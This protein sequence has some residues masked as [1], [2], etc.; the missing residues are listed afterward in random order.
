MA[1]F[2][3]VGMTCCV[4]GADSAD[5]WLLA[6]ERSRWRLRRGRRGAGQA[7]LCTGGF[8]AAIVGA[9]TGFVDGADTGCGAC[10]CVNSRKAQSR[11]RD[12]R[13]GGHGRSDCC[14]SG[15]GFAAAL[16]AGC[17]TGTPAGFASDRRPCCAGSVG[18]GR[19]RR[20]IS[21]RR[22]SDFGFWRGNGRMTVG[23]ARAVASSNANQPAGG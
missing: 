5:G 1:G 22:S 19:S 6:A 8:A 23:W 13:A 16:A 21:N 9:G 14:A 3:T 17:S 4:T 18:V 12:L 2:A 20:G 7:R 11:L 10:S 15:A